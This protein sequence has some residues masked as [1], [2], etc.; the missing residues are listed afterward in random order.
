[1]DDIYKKK[2]ALSHIL[3][4]NGSFQLDQFVAELQGFSLG[5]RL[6]HW[7]TKSYELHKAV[8]QTQSAIDSLIDGFVEAY[9]GMAGGAR[10]EFK[11]A[12]TRIDDPDYII[13]CLKKLALT[14][15]SLLNIRDEML[16]AVYKYKYL[17][18]LE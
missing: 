6:T 5:L 12:I 8:E 9:I 2:G 13:S 3:A 16:Q 17:K 1:M 10:P 7:H 18:T 11:S 15:T 4:G 14:D